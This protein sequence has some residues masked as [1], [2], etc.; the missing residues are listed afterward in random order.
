ML[1]QRVNVHGHVRQMEPKEEI[2][3]LG[4]QADSMGLLKEAP[5]RR[6]LEGQEAW[7]KRFKSLAKKIDKQRRKNEAKYNKT[8]S[9][10]RELGLVQMSDG[11]RMSAQTNT[12]TETTGNG[13][14]QRDRRWGPLDLEGEDPPP[15]A[16]AARRDT[17][18]TSQH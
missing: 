9:R 7:D 17:V 3:C 11:D 1:R 5:A 16:I 8:L 10:A 18:L 15:S 12:S 13:V 2:P 6:W 4:I 14:I